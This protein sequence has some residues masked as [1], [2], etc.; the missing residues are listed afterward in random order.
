MSTKLHFQK[1]FGRNFN[2]VERVSTSEADMQSTREM[3]MN[4]RCC[5]VPVLA[6]PGVFRCFVGVEGTIFV[7]IH[8]TSQNSVRSSG[9][10]ALDVTKNSGRNF[11]FFWPIF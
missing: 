9:D 1:N 8:D 3:T 7:E 5:L 6:R 4:R 11:S 10:V 2:A